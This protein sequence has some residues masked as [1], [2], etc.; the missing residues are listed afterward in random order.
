MFLKR[1]FEMETSS[2]LEFFFRTLYIANMLCQI[3]RMCLWA[4][5]PCGRYY[6]VHVL[7]YLTTSR[8]KTTLFSNCVPWYTSRDMFNACICYVNSEFLEIGASTTHLVEWPITENT[9]LTLIQFGERESALLYSTRSTE[10]CSNGCFTGRGLYVFC[11]I[12]GCRMA[13]T[14]LTVH[15]LLLNIMV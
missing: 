14:C 13:L 8:W 6:V 12:P 11:S 7:L 15:S 3:E 4:E 1:L 9:C 2:F 10:T 5:L